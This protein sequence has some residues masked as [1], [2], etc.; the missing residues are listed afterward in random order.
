[1]TIS[2]SHSRGKLWIGLAL[3]LVTLALFL[4]SVT[5]QFLR[6]D[7]QQ[8]VTENQH[9]QAGLTWSSVVWAFKSFRATNWHPL[10]WLSHMLDCQFYGL[11]PAGHHLTNVLFHTA[12]SVLLF[13]VLAQLTGALWRSAAVAALFAWHPLHVES[14]AWI[15]ERKDL[16]CAFFWMLTIWAYARYVK[17]LGIQ[18]P[19]PR[20]QSHPTR[21]YLLALVFFALALMSKPMAVTL[22]FVFLLLDYWPLQRLQIGSPKSESKKLVALIGEKAPFLILSGVSCALTLLAQKQAMVSTAGLGI[23]QRFGHAP[24]AYVHYLGVM[25]VPRHL[26]IYYPYDKM[27]PGGG[28]LLAVAL[29][30][31]ITTIVLWSGRRL[32]YLATGWFWF[33]G[34]L[35]PVIGLVQVGE[36]AWADRYT[37]LPY[38]GLFIALVWGLRDLAARVRVARTILPWLAA[39]T[40]VALLV[41][42]SVQLSYWKDTRT[43]FEH[44]DR[45]TQNNPLSATLLGS[46]LATEGKYD[47]AI[48]FYRRALSYSPGFPEAHFYLGHAFDQQGKLDEAIA[49]Y[50]KAVWFKPIEEQTHIRLG[51][52]LAKQQKLEEATAQYEAALKAN[53]ESAVAHNNLAKLLHSQGRLDD[54]ILH[55]SAALR[56][57]PS[58]AQAHNNLGVLL[59]QKGRTAEGVAQLQEALRLRP[60]DTE[61]QLNL[62]LG[63]ADQQQWNEAA[64]LFAKTVTTATSDPNIHYRF[65]VTLAHLHKTR[66][67]MSQFASALLLRQDL[68]D[69][70]NGL[71][72]ILATDPDPQLRNG[73]Q[74]VA[75]AERACELTGRKDPDKLKTLAAAYAETGQ[76][77]HAIVDAQAALDIASKN[78]LKEMTDECRLMLGAFRTGKPWREPQ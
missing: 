54:A 55:Y 74:A 60:G 58:L 45:V 44:V 36:Q 73:P 50:Q 62:A 27:I 16:L 57:G 72:W 13:L 32:P 17:V 9:V 33:V 47:A 64:D 7:D 25:L 48:P 2:T 22:P 3:G 56:F 49:E 53:P 4:P 10:T 65:A 15:A 31:L 38:I 40:S 63:L 78:G 59:L 71:S 69:A 28:I 46:L 26:A 12:N 67:A 61:T 29:L 5:H 18:S 30:A 68:P 20:V 24:V 51:V 66:E 14:V 75:M 21:L 41:V 77:S 11:Q 43:L 8:Y 23:S 52:A 34:T 1:V 37:Y 70:L 35:V 39:T 76:F 19:G 42:T 6:Y